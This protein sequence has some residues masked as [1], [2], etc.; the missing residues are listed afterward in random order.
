MRRMVEYAWA[1]LSVSR[2]LLFVNFVTRV[3]PDCDCMG[4][5]H[6][7]LTPDIGVLAS[8][9]PVAL[10][11]ACLDLVTQ[12]PDGPDSPVKAGAGQNKFRAFRPDSQGELQ[13]E[14]AE[15]LGLGSRSYKLLEI[16][17]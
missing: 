2:P 6:P 12:A 9:D 5:T 1:A 10:D 7:P 15:E 14:I 16:R 13:L 8:T 3:V 4:D 17:R 11:S